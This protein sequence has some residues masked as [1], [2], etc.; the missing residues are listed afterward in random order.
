MSLISVTRYEHSHAE[1]NL[2]QSDI[3]ISNTHGD[4]KIYRAWSEGVQSTNKRRERMHHE[5]MPTLAAPDTRRVVALAEGI[6]GDKVKVA[7]RASSGM[8]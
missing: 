8:S 1:G 2:K 6:G 4:D 3:H 5:R 7:R